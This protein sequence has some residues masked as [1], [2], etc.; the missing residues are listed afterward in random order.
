MTDASQVTEMRLVVTTD[1]YERALHFYRDLLGLREVAAFTA[2]GGHVTILEAGRATLELADPAHAAYVD[3]V[4]VGRRVA[5]HIRVAF[6]VE[7]AAVAT[8][9]L[10][11]GRH[12]GHRSPDGHPV[13]LVQR[14]ARGR[15]RAPAHAVQ[16]GRR[17]TAVDREVP[18]RGAGSG[19]TGARPGRRRRGRHRPAGGRPAPAPS[20]PRR[21]RS[22]TITSRCI[23]W[24]CAGSGHCG[25]RWSGASWNAN[26]DVVSSRATTTK[27]SDR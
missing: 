12:R 22:S 25:A 27:S 18:T 17:L 1:D 24:G 21:A 11:A 7:D 20:A 4:E 6:G 8:E 3:R 14:P 26:P 10:R 5:G 16:R 23:C 19:R 9:R 13:G 15:G 2:D